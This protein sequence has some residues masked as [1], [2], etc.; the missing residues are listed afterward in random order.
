MKWYAYP[1][2]VTAYCIFVAL[3]VVGLINSW[4]YS[5]FWLWA[6]AAAIVY[7]GVAFLLALTKWSDELKVALQVAL[8]LTPLIMLVNEKQEEPKQVRLYVVPENFEGRLNIIFASPKEMLMRSDADTLYF[9]FD[10]LGRVTVADDYRRVMDDMRTHLFYQL[11]DSLQPI[12]FAKVKQL[13]NDTSIVVVED[14]SD[15]RSGRLK[16]L[17]YLLG[18]SSEVRKKVK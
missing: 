16:H 6:G 5:S 17:Y 12:P 10:T 3:F 8:I 2:A 1:I 13:K 15:Y 9:R 11:R 18:P 7:L 14:G 4:E